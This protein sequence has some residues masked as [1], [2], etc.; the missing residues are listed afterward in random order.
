[1]DGLIGT[2][3]DT[4]CKIPIVGEI[5]K[6]LSN[7]ISKLVSSVLRFELLREILQKFAA[8]MLG[9]NLHMVSNNMSGARTFDMVAAGADVSGNDF[10]HHGIGGV[11]LKPEQ[12]AQNLE[13]AR[14]TQLAEYNQKSF[15][16]K[17]ADTESPHSP[18]GQL[19]LAVPTNTAAFTSSVNSAFATF[20]KNPFGKIADS[21]ASLFNPRA[22]AAG[23]TP[24]KDPFG[25][26][27]YGYPLDDPVFKADPDEYW[28]NYCTDETYN[29]TKDWNAFAAKEQNWNEDTFEPENPQT[30]QFAGR[31]PGNIYGTNGCLLI[32]AAVGSA[33]AIFTDDVLSAE[34]LADLQPPPTGGVAGPVDC[35]AP[36]GVD[37]S[38]GEPPTQY[39][40]A[41]I[42]AA[43]GLT[44]P[45]YPKPSGA[46][47]SDP[48]RQYMAY[49]GCSD[50]CAIQGTK[51]GRPY[52]RVKYRNPPLQGNTID[53]FV[54]P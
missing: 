1:L 39:R 35:S 8:W 46:V 6:A 29:L 38:P 16:A 2:V 37:Q 47:P 23:F 21:F 7:A 12:V 19:A 45:D 28:K 17:L 41:I 11:A 18:I 30:G 53:V 26:T 50:D 22:N 48:G 9:V 52:I 10:A 15:F 20:I 25:V 14:K 5:C 4:V 27:Q 32:Q 42:A 49:D 13:Y 3:V 44:C 36:S 43:E 31:V 34:E 40:D 24:G 51:D 54:S 33:G